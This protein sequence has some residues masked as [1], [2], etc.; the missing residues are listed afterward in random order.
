MKTELK[1]G[2][3]IALAGIALMII[4]D[5]AGFYD[6]RIQHLN[7]VSWVSY[8]IP[9]IGLFFTIKEKRDKDLGGYISYGRCVGTGALTSL[10]S[11]IIGAVVQFVYFSFINPNFKEYLMDFQRQQMLENGLPAEQV[12]AAMGMMQFMLSPVMM[13]ITAFIGAMIGAVIISLIL[14]AILKKT[15]PPEFE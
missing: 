6:E 15:T 2:L 11:G 10:V 9:I 12:D 1:Y 4:L 5:L 14:G 13:T 3:I 8:I 7:A